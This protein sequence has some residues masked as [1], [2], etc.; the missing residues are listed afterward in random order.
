MNYGWR[1]VVIALV[2]VMAACAPTAPATSR[3]L[4]ARTPAAWVVVAD[5]SFDAGVFR[6][7]YPRQWRVVNLGGADA[8]QLRVAFVAPE[9]GT[10][11]LTQVDSPG[12]EGGQS[13][14]LAND[15][16]LHISI[17]EGNP[18]AEEFQQQAERLIF[19]IRASPGR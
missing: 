9:G 13:L 4:Q 16:L 19:S 11:T 1:P 10:V 2:A 17:D 12:S 3:P 7:D 5:G 15:T 14:R 18:G 8:T 6:L